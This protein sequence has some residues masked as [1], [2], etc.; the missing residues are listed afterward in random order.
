MISLTIEQLQDLSRVSE[1]VQH[2][3][4]VV[5]N[6]DPHFI[7]RI[8]VVDWDSYKQAQSHQLELGIKKLRDEYGIKLDLSEEV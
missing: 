5:D 3:L 2:L 8:E 7:H 4:R 6:T 1:S